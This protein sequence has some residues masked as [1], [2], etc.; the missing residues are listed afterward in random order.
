MEVHGIERDR[1]LLGIGAP[2][3]GLGLVSPRGGHGLRE[4]AASA[5]QAAAGV[6]EPQDKSA[7]H[8]TE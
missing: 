3:D 2:L 8:R 6:V 1:F 5:D 7:A 4:Q